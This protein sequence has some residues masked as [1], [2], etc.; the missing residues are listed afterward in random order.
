MKIFTVTHMFEIHG[1]H[2]F[3]CSVNNFST[4]KKAYDFMKKMFEQTKEMCL[5]QFVVKEGFTVDCTLLD[6]GAEVYV[7]NEGYEDYYVLDVFEIFEAELDD[8][9]VED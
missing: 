4:H 9:T 7:S 5:N 2:A 1:D 3:V 8:D 6:Y